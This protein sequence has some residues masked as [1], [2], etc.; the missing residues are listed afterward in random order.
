V[1]EGWP[2]LTGKEAGQ[3][4][5]DGRF[6]EGTVYAGVQARLTSWAETIRRFGAAGSGGG[7]AEP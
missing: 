7:K 5:A 2:I 6:A 4:D 1:E 3:A